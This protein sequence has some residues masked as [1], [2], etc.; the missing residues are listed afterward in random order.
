MVEAAEI[1]RPMPQALLRKEPCRVSS[2]GVRS[3]G[4]KVALASYAVALPMS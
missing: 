2:L 4:Q 3:Q 1:C